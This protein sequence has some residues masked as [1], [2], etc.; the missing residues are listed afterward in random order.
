FCVTGGAQNPVK[1][2]N[3]ET[4]TSE[5]IF[6]LQSLHVHSSSIVELPDGGLLACWFEGSGERTANDFMIKG[7][8]LKKGESKWSETFVLTD[9][10]GHPDCNPILFID[11]NDRLHLLWIVVQ[12]NRWET[13][14]LKSR[15]SSDYENSKVPR[16]EWQDVILL[17]PGEEFA[18]TIKTR[19]RESNTPDLAW[20]EYAPLYER[21]IYDAAKDPKKRETGWMTRTHPIILPDGRILLPLYSDGFNLSIIAINCSCLFRLIFY[22][23]R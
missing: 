8:R 7:A 6:P 16:W 17:K 12:A 18:E 3:K 9:T 19:F 10:P 2:S 4:L 13:S 14:V 11:K 23:S 5:F 20:A 15:V 1:N 22:T 21:M